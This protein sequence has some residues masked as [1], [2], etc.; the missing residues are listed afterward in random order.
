MK[1]L[2]AFF[3]SFVIYSCSK[4]DVCNTSTTWNAQCIFYTVSSKSA[5]SLITL[6]SI[7]VKGLGIS[8]FLYDT[9][10]AKKSI[11]LP[12]DISSDTSRYIYGRYS[13]FDTLTIAHQ[14]EPFYISKACGY[15]YKQ[16]L[17]SVSSTKHLIQSVVINEI[18]I[19]ND[20]KENI[21]IY[22]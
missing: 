11:A 14:T 6:D 19:E 4:P 13:T 15:G 22:Y 1:H 9:A 16:T 10:L 3:I 20:A 17:L 18:S 5:D 21:K 12:L 8:T 7:D 2:L